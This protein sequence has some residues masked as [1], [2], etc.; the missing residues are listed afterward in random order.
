MTPSRTWVFC[1]A[2][3]LLAAC[4]GNDPAQLVASAKDYLAK[5]D[6]A[7]AAIQLKN[8]LQQEPTNGE[9]RY[10]L[11][12]SLLETGDVVSAEKELR[13]ALEYRYPQAAVL[14]LLAKAMVRMGEGKKLVEEFGTAKLDDPAAQAALLTEIGT[15]HLAAGEQKQAREAFAAALAARP[16]DA[17]ARIG[18]ARIAALGGD[19]PGAMKLADEVLAKSPAQPEALALK[20]ELL[21]AQNEF[22]PAKRALAELVKAQPAN[23]HA[24]FVLVS[25]LIDTKGFAE[26]RT[27][28]DAMKKAVPGDLRARYLEAL[29]EFRQGNPAKA[30]ESIQEVLRVAPDHAPS[31]LLAGTI[32]L[33]LKAY[34][35]AEDH[36]RR[37]VAQ[38]PK[39]IVARRLLAA[40]YLGAGQ[41]AKAEEALEP[42]LKLAPE[43]P[44]L[45]RLAGEAA[46]A[47]GDLAKASRF[48]E[49]AAAGDKGDAIVRT[50]LA[51]TRFA[52]GDVDA[53]L[54]ELEAASAIDP[55]Q[56]QADLALVLAHLRRREYDKALAAAATLEKKQPANP[57]TF[58]VKGEVHLAKGDRKSARANFEKALELQFDYFPAAAALARLDIA[59]KQP[60][61]ARKRFEAIIAKA[62]KNERA[63]LGLAD[64]QAATGT[65][66]KEIVP[67]IE[68]AVKANPM[69]VPARLAAIN[70]QLRMREPKA[71]LA[72]AQAAA[73]AL[74][75]NPQI[76][77]ALGRVQIAAGEPNQA[78]ETFN[79]LAAIMPGSPAPLMLAA[80]AH[81]AKKDYDAATQALGRALALQPDRLDVHREAIAVYLAAGKP[82]EALAD[83]RALQKARP[84]EAAGYV[85]E[86][87]I[88]A[89]QKKFTEAANAYREALA[90][91][92]APLLALRRHVLL[93]A[94]GKRDEAEAVL[95]RWVRDHPQDAVVRLYLADRDLRRKDYKAAE[96]GYRELLAVAPENP[97]ALNN[98]A[99]VLAEKKDPSALEYAEKAHRLAPNSPAIA[100][101]LGWILVERG[102][103]KRGVELLGRA[104]AAAP[105]ALEI[106][107]HYAKALLKTGDKAGARKEL[108]AVQQ[109]PDPSP[110]KAE[111][112]ALLKQL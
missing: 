44:V 96:R 67:I 112:E 78:V 51:Q 98:L 37:V 23:G 49:R 27:E 62:P 33:Q 79:R 106:R 56:Y 20:A 92:P 41:P 7:A 50:R 72:A 68:Q 45:L 110:L 104:A 94:A 80:R 19:L 46:L 87:E 70:V 73:D 29:L 57:L 90:R 48:F 102:D 18:E 105:N 108:E 53:G 9:A 85:F 38:H 66:L 60:A 40:T 88:F 34:G 61:A 75:D 86:G 16:G 36:L 14:P 31:R 69:S 107:M 32:E 95:A 99:W 17:R 3:A 35:T 64:V 54:K 83:A 111:A 97:I 26:A 2:F 71:A 58:A 15:A 43:D 63:I 39:N 77:E 11:G 47:G 82:E 25:L 12:V 28:L 30:K 59:D 103:T 65:P 84:K 55:G 8:A 91:Q 81:L 6:Y 22:E 52:T 74:P 100:D 1:A 76:L 42:A 109:S 21:L 13:R 10:L 5:R 93:G 24:R 4:G 101:T 89:A